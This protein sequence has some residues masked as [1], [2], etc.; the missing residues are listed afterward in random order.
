MSR[1]D[2]EKCN[3]TIQADSIQAIVVAAIAGDLVNI[4]AV[5]CSMQAVESFPPIQSEPKAISKAITSSSNQSHMTCTKHGL[6]ELEKVVNADDSD[7][8]ATGQFENKLNPKCMTIQDWVESQSKDKIISEIVHLFK[9]KK[10]C[11]CKMTTNDN[12]EIK[13]FIRQ[14]N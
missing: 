6:S 3:E 8:P 2:W 14:C 10:L 9:S 4:E 7:H 11:C 12:N 1:I 13:Q 5:S